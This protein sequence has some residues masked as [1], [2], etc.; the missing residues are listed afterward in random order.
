M[1]SRSWCYTL[2]NPTELEIETFKILECKLHRCGS[3]VGEEGTPHLQ[4]TIIFGKTCRLSALKKISPRAHWEACKSEEASINYCSKTG[5]MLINIDL[6]NQGSRT[7]LKSLTDAV[8]KGMKI[9]EIADNYPVEYVKFHNGIEKLMAL[10]QV[11][12]NFKPEIIWIHGQTG[13]GKTRYV[14]ET[15]PSLWISG[16]NL[17]WWQGYE[18]QEAVLIDDFR[19][20]FCTFH[21]LLRILDRYPYTVEVKGGHRQLNSKRM[22][23]TSCYAPDEVYETRE[24]INQLLRRIDRV[25]LY[26]LVESTVSDV[27]EVV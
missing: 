19:R 8:G 2:N 17:K 24:D 3:E 4:G 11:P 9:S 23:I 15:E 12:R 21:E 26:P 20:D 22:Y 5:V 6:R 1:T 16:K 7:D 27:T 13:V 10:R 18:N 25:V 14:V